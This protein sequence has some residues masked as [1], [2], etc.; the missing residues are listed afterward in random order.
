MGPQALCWCGFTH[1]K[2]YHMEGAYTCLPFSI[3]K[4][5]PY[6]LEAF[7]RCGCDPEA[8]GQVGIVLTADIAKPD[9]EKD[10]V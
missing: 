6:L 4:D 1:R 3:L 2:Q 9:K 7:R 8:H 5:K 10:D